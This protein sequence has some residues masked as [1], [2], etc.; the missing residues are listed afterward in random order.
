MRPAA[1]RRPPPAV[2]PTTPPRR[3]QREAISAEGSVRY[4]TRTF[5]SSSRTR[6][7]ERQAP[8]SGREVAGSGVGTAVLVAH[9]ALIRSWCASRVENVTVEHAERH[10]VSNTGAVVLD[11]A[12]DAGWWALTWENHALGG[13]DVD[14]TEADTPAGQPYVEPGR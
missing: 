1:R 9:G 6:P 8:R 14:G 7:G 10:A 3:H 13:R 12:P 2:V 11:G 5:R 4:A